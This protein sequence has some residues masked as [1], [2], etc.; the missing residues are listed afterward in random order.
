MNTKVIN[1]NDYYY[2][3]VRKNIKYFRLLK[4]NILNKD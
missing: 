2:D 3:I 4:K 1:S